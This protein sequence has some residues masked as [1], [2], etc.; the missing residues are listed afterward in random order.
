MH[1]PFKNGVPKRLK[2]I[3]LG[4]YSLKGFVLSSQG[5][6]CVSSVQSFV[7]NQDSIVEQVLFSDM[8]GF[9]LIAFKVRNCLFS[10]GVRKN[11]TFLG[12][13]LGQAVN[14]V[15]GGRATCQTEDL[16]TF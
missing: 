2:E 3:V 1:G 5:H 4:I 10:L 15:A 8:A 11:F 6:V 16:P 13:G 7:F 9:L 12:F 14:E